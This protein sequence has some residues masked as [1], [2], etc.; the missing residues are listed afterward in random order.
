MY[1]FLVSEPKNTCIFS[2]CGRS[3]DL[4]SVAQYDKCSPLHSL[5]GRNFFKELPFMIASAREV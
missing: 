5:S 1:T 3:E 2:F 4:Q